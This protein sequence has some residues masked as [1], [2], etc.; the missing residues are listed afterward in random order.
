M[1]II[2]QLIKSI[3]K[4]GFTMVELLIFM[5]IF[6]LII[7]VLTDLVIAG[8]EVKLDSEANNSV[9]TDGRFILKRLS[10]DLRRSTQVVTPVA[11]GSQ[12][13]SLT[14][15]ID[16]ANKTY[17]LIDGDLYLN[18]GDGE[19]RINSSDTTVST[20]SFSKIGQGEDLAVLIQ[21]NLI[22]K[23]TKHTGSESRSFQ[24][25]IGIRP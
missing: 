15:T 24:S 21:L 10:Y 1:I 25:T 20:I 19:Q 22:S 9:E 14:L 11:F 12:G 23:I 2:K 18:Q 8:L 17:S 3:S 7:V 4:K 6:T 16:G 13:G 5:G